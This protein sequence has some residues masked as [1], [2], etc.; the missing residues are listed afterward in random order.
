MSTI[1]LLDQITIDKIAAGEVIERPVSVVKELVENA[2]D[3]GATSITVEIESGG[4]SLIRITDNGKGISREEVPKAFLRHSTSKIRQVEDLHVINTLGFRGEA[5]SSVAA[6]AKVELITKTKEEDSGTKYQIEG[7]K[8]L[9]IL[10]IGAP[11]G[12][13]F[14][15]RQLFYNIPAR[16]SF[17]KT[18]ITEAGHIQDLLIR[19]ALSH[20]EVS[21][22]FMNNNQEKLRT[23]GN[24]NLKDVIYALYGREITNQLLPVN[25][26]KDGLKITG[27]IG[28]PEI[29]R[30]N[31]NYETFFVNGRYI[32]SAM[33]SKSIEDAY[34]SYVMQHKFP[35]VV[36]NFALDG[37]KVDIN[38]HPTKMELRFQNQNEIFQNIYECVHQAL[39]EPELIPKIT[40][41]KENNSTKVK[42]SLT[43]SPTTQHLT[44]EDNQGSPFL[45]RPRSGAT[46]QP[47]IKEPII[48]AST[49][50]G[51]LREEKSEYGETPYS[52]PSKPS[53]E[54]ANKEEEYFLEKMKARVLEYHGVDK[55]QPSASTQE[56]I[57]DSNLDS[58]QEHIKGESTNKIESS[59]SIEDQ[60]TIFDEDHSKDLLAKEQLNLFESEL[61]KS[62]IKP[63]YHIIG[64]V[65][66]TY[67]LVSFEDSLY[68]ID[69]HAAHEKVLYEKVLEDIK[70]REHTSQQIT[71]PLV[72]NLT[73]LE[74]NLLKD[75]MDSFTRI[76]FEIEEFGGDSYTVRAVPA[77]LFSI[78]QKE[79]FIELLDTLST[80]ITGKMTT[81]KI[82]HKIATLACKGAVKG[83]Q[84]LSKEEI[85]QLLE[86]LLTL[87]NPYFCPHGRPTIVAFTKKELEK[88][89]KRIV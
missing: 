85:D 24:G 8:E 73:M 63:S 61:L 38:V 21:F 84:Q 87:D 11:E 82:D 27:F 49:K 48:P 71:P 69:Q 3:A 51:F 1:Q 13:T 23:Y 14:I 66:N 54:Y 17:L 45:L 40:L 57:D 44:N 15:I 67:W 16:K 19:L 65:F 53:V 47:P 78:A 12:S 9:S 59:S 52:N 62:K 77:N 43:D 33:I 37:S 88:K 7:G 75:H 2:I 56:H 68:I 79:L 10:D 46:V 30:G 86:D 25:Y 39:L 5:L 72:L 81:D 42:G 74:A 31:R 80:D 18:P 20:P 64:Q 70:T 55:E 76:G 35:F 41:D 28:K 32:K 60:T 6:V 89:F 34:K 4:I 26:E 36:L 22:T 58:T 50:E 29:N 83:R